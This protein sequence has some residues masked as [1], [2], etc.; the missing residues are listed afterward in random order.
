MVSS[1]TNKGEKL[2][3]PQCMQKDNVYFCQ[4]KNT[5]PEAFC[6]FM[7]AYSDRD[8]TFQV[9][10]F[11]YSFWNLLSSVGSPEGYQFLYDTSP[12]RSLLSNEN[13]AMLGS[14]EP[15][16]LVSLS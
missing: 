11:I 7:A 4:K 13:A 6:N 5:L 12:W 14:V 9:I 8:A 15:D 1:C 2:I 10:L 16:G 3:L